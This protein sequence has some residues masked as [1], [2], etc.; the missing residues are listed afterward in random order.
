LK[1]LKVYKQTY[2]NKITKTE[3]ERKKLEDKHLIAT[4]KRNDTFSFE[5]GKMKSKLIQKS[6][7]VAEADKNRVLALKSAKDANPEKKPSSKMICPGDG[8]HKIKMKN[9]YPLNFKNGF[10]CHSCS[11]KLG[12][13]KIVALKT[14]GHVH[15]KDCL[16][17]FCV[18][19]MTCTCG[20][21]FLSGDCIK[22]E[23]SKSSFAKHNKVEASTY[24]PAFT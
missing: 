14:C 21:K 18:Q 5:N 17:D 11:K 16:K 2:D 3:E 8:K 24:K 1:K 20:V 23:E 19:T 13:Q 15:C 22:M 12:F 9:I 7:W 6:F 4:D 10:N